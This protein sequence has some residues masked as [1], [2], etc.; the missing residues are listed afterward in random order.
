M[1]LDMDRAW[2]EKHYQGDK[3]AELKVF[4]EID[5]CGHD[6]RAYGYPFPIKA[7]HDRTR[8]SMAERVVLRKQIID[9]AVSKGM[10]RSLFK[11]ASTA[12]GHN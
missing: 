12:T 6:Q 1:R 4:Q 2:W 5:Y 7:C 11:D 3:K 8:L 10:K 9:A